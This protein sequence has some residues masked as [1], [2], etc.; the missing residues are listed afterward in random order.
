M[1]TLL[2]S[3]PYLSTPESVIITKLHSRFV[4]INGYPRSIVE[5]EISTWS[6]YAPVLLHHFHASRELYP[7]FTTGERVKLSIG[8]F[9]RTFTKCNLLNQQTYL[10]V[11]QSFSTRVD[12]IELTGEAGGEE[13][14]K[15][16]KSQGGW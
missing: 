13:F 2:I 11:I 15:M 7:G 3:A 12:S 5:R 10:E 6:Y 9:L 4:R 14:L 1:A 16:R 8:L